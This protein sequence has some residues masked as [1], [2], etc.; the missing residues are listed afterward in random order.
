M[1]DRPK[2][3]YLLAAMLFV[4]A[5]VLNVVDDTVDPN[6]VLDLLLAGLAALSVAFLL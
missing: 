2:I 3:A 1:T 5:L 4:V 6:L